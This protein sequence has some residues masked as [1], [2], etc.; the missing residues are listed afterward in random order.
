[1]A[2]SRRS[3]RF[4]A[5]SAMALPLFWAGIL[6]RTAAG[7]MARRDNARSWRP[8]LHEYPGLTHRGSC[9]VAYWHIC[10]MLRLVKDGRFR[11]GSGSSWAASEDDR[12]RHRGAGPVMP[13][14]ESSGPWTG[15]LS[16]VPR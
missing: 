4:W 12:P 7:W 6:H 15:A 3:T 11:S 8:G 10:D 1:M 16:I 14:N 2:A 9:E 13:E 5:G